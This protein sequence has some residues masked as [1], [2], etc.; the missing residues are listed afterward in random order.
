MLSQSL[1][2][3]Q[4]NLLKYEE[5]RK[6]LHEEFVKFIQQSPRQGKVNGQVELQIQSL[7]Q[8]VFRLETSV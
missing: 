3:V 7:Q 1:T 4:Q 8:T 2:Q 6:N 5:S